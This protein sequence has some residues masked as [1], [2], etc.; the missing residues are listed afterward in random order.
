MLVFVHAAN[1]ARHDIADTLFADPFANLDK[2]AQLQV[3]VAKP[4]TR[5]FQVADVLW[6]DARTGYSGPSPSGGHY[7]FFPGGSI[8]VA[9]DASNSAIF[10]RTYGTETRRSDG[11]VS[12]HLLSGIFR[13]AIAA[14]VEKVTGNKAY[15]LDSTTKGQFKTVQNSDSPQDPKK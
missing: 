4:L 3:A 10:F 13:D 5:Q 14:G 1:A 6:F 8:T 11:Y 9:V 7:R 15:F 2:S 12:T